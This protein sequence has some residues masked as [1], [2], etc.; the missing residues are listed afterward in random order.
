MSMRRIALLAVVVALAAAGCQAWTGV[1][2]P[3]RLDEDG[4]T[5]TERTSAIYAAVIRQLLTN[6]HYLGEGRPFERVFVVRTDG[7]PFV[8]TESPLRPFSPAVERAILEALRDLPPVRVVPDLDTVMVDEKSCR[9][10][11]VTRGG[12][13][14]SLGP[15]AEAR[16]GAVTVPSF[17][18][19]GC[20]GKNGQWLTYVLELKDLGWRVVGTKGPIAIS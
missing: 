9:G 15:I 8:G 13:L 20:L 2:A 1:S 7:D 17:L 6:D 12:V 11:A 19:S 5:G 18:L 4:D 3:A 16:G 14:V 10:L